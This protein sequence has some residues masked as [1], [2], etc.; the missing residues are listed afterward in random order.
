[1]FYGLSSGRLCLLRAMQCGPSLKGACLLTFLMCGPS[2]GAEA[3]FRQSQLI[4][5]F[6]LSSVLPSGD[7]KS[8]FSSSLAT[9]TIFC[10][11]CYCYPAPCPREAR[12]PLFGVCSQGP[13]SY[14]FVKLESVLEL[15]L[16]CVGSV[17]HSSFS[18]N[19]H[20]SISVSDAPGW[21][22]A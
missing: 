22:A 6:S 20:F 8:H 15:C 13:T 17:L 4:S 12:V 19:F 3:P 2:P 1:M 21:F 7:W 11:F 9:V 5:R 10:D 14:S 16:K 18:F